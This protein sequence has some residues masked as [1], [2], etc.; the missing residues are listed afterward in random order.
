[1]RPRSLA[2]DRRNIGIVTRRLG[3]VRLQEVDGRKLER[4]LHELRSG[5]ATGNRLAERTVLQC[6]STLRQIL[7]H[8][9]VSD[10]IAVN[11]CT[12]VAKHLRPKAT[13]TRKPNP[14]IPEEVECLIAA[15]S[16]AYRPI[17]ATCAFTGARIREVPGLRWGGVDAAA[18]LITFAHQID[19]EGT[20]LV[21][22]KTEAGVRMNALVPALEPY[23]GRQ[24]RMRSRWSGDADFAF[25][26]EEGQAARVPKRSPRAGAG[27][28]ESRAS[29]RLLA[30]PP[31]RVH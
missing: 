16:P 8:A 18:A 9:V 3:H 28:G 5:A 25:Q 10:L 30:P 22:T 20:S 14:L 29:G 15:T 23:L 12:N 27:R 13:S 1:V 4:F 31:P 26:R 21:P 7:D 2:A 6:F 24:A 11:P 17:I 19:V